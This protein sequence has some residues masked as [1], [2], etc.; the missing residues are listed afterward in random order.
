MAILGSAIANAVK[1]N[2]SD[3]FCSKNSFNMK[4]PFRKQEKWL[5]AV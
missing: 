4:K 5:T 2:I 1:I 3:Q